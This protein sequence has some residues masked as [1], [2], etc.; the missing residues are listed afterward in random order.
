MGSTVVSLSFLPSILP[1]YRISLINNAIL[2]IAEDRGRMEFG[3]DV[4]TL[5]Y[6]V[7]YAPGRLFV[8]VVGRLR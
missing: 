6:C 5:F 8:H 2:V 7:L 4:G 3:L 1:T